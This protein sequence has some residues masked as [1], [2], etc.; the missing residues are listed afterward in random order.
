MEPSIKSEPCE[1]L[2]CEQ[3]NENSL[4]MHNPQNL[5]RSYEDMVDSR[6]KQQYQINNFYGE[7]NHVT[8]H[9]DIENGG[10]NQ[11]YNMPEPNATTNA[12]D[13]RPLKKYK[14]L[15]EN[16]LFNPPF[17]KLVEKFILPSQKEAIAARC[18]SC[19]KIVK[20][21]RG[22]SS[23]FIKHMKRAHPEVNQIYENYK[24]HKIKVGQFPTLAQIQEAQN[25]TS[26]IASG[27][28]S[29][30]TYSNDETNQF[31]E[32]DNPLEAASAI[33]ESS[34][35]NEE[36]KSC[37]E[38]QLPVVNNNKQCV[39]QELP[40]KTL[41]MLQQMMEEKLQ[42][43]AQKK[44]Y[45]QLNN[46][47]NVLIKSQPSNITGMD[48]AILELRTEV[49]NLKKECSVLR[50]ALQQSQASKRQLQNELQ[51]VERQLHERKLIIRN[52]TVKDPEQPLESVQKLLSNILNLEDIK[53]LNCCVIPSTKSSANTG[54]KECLSLEFDSSQA[55]KAI[56]RQAHKL[57]DT[58]IFIE[59]DISP[60]QRKRK[61]KLMV[62]R[63]E[64][65][66]RKPDLKVLV[67]DTTL[68][69]ES[70][71]FYWDDVEGL[72]HDGKY[73]AIELNG[74]DY[75]KELSGLDLREFINVL[76]NYNIQIS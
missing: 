67:R 40:A 46:K 12:A 10:F 58:G 13:G 42:N 52:L 43:Y 66:R 9:I 27:S 22:I 16:V 53:I 48:T 71:K 38:S 37:L 47:I 8:H 18:Y 61:N 55:C 30:A 44:E 33:Y 25:I 75:L 70:K 28:D 41:E 11:D 73:E 62:L 15:E 59:T 1:T 24:T 45:D 57:K 4:K 26:N 5:K 76:Q 3:E 32:V 50:V 51:T 6:N 23:N 60:F 63:K 19:G 39:A 49:D 21:N 54:H 17:F 35:E 68:V 64:L 36:E 20:G 29:N 69:V 2:Y 7:A 34:D 31:N 74:V 65:L 72:C 14:R 56:L